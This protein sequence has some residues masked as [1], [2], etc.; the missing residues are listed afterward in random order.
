MDVNNERLKILL[1]RTDSTFNALL[2]EPG[3]IELKH[4]YE[5]AKEEL[6]AYIAA[7]RETLSR[8]RSVLPR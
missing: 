4:A 2:K 3:S 8:R 1:H 7:R 5:S 6:D